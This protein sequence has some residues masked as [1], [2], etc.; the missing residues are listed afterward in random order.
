MSDEDIS[1]SGV[2]EE[3]DHNRIELAIVGR[4][5][6]G[7]STLMNRILGE[8]RVMTGPRAGLTRDSI[9]VDW[10]YKNHSIRLIPKFWL[11]SKWLVI[12]N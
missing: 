9:A 10:T 12:K 2:S 3:P 4:P 1:A 7:K 6:V 11:L 5:N 8:N